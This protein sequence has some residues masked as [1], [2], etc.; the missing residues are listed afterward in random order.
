MYG[1]FKYEI[2]GVEKTDKTILKN[3]ESLRV[4]EIDT[5]YIEILKEIENAEHLSI[6]LEIRDYVYIYNLF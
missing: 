4:D 2:D 6:V 5:Y 3:V 1:Y